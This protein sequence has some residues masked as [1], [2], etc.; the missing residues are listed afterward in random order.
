[1]VGLWG[2]VFI[3]EELAARSVTEWCA[4]ARVSGKYCRDINPPKAQIAVMQRVAPSDE[5]A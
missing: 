4:V 1:M 5:F 2:W 3:G